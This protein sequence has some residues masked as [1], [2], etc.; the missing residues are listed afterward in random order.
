[1]MHSRRTGS[2]TD[3]SYGRIG[4]LLLE[5]AQVRGGGTAAR[6]AGHIDR[7]LRPV[8]RRSVVLMSPRCDV[9]ARRNQQSR[10]VHV[11]APRGGMQRRVM[12]WRRR[13]R[14]RACTLTQKPLDDF[15]PACIDG[16]HHDV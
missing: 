7:Y 2:S 16:C 1:M 10:D 8:L 5:S 14:V 9:G 15:V 11:A 6:M 4:M 12:R 13:V 3:A